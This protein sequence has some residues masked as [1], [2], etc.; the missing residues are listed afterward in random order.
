MDEQI[1]QTLLIIRECFVYKIPPRQTT[2]GYKAG[3]WNVDNFLWSGRLTI[4]AKGEQ[5]IIRLEDVKTDDLFAICPVSPGS[6]E[7]VSDSSRYFV[8]RVDDGRGRHAFI[9]MGFTERNVAFDFSAALADHQRYV[10]Q[11]KEQASSFQK[12]K[13]A[14]KLNLGLAEGQKITV[15][16]KIPTKSSS[17][18]SSSSRTATGTGILLPPPGSTSNSSSS[19]SSQKFTQPTIFDKLG[20]DTAFASFDFGD[21]TGGA[22][23]SGTQSQQ[24]DFGDPFPSQSTIKNQQDKP[25]NSN[26]F[27]FSFENTNASTNP[28]QSTKP[29][30]NTSNPFDWTT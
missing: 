20:N 6:V 24:F 22:N 27:D 30:T 10:K 1:E 21:F 13:D 23:N 19:S 7:S 26:L 16:L 15:N 18:S 2:S 9:G 5:A 17:S 11:L 28:Q 8:L 25:A 3:D 4:K 14:P 12:M 29:S